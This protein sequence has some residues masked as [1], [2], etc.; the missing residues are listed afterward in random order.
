MLSNNVAKNG[1][2]GAVYMDMQ[3]RMNFTSYIKFEN[4]TA[5]L[6]GAISSYTESYASFLTDA[7]VHFLKNHA[8]NSGGAIY[9]LNSKIIYHGWDYNDTN[10]IRESMSD[11]YLFDS[12]N[13]SFGGA[14]TMSGASKLILNPNVKISLLKIKHNLLV[15]QSLLKF[16]LVPSVQQSLLISDLNVLSC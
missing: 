7:T 4:N 1:S 10:T 14:I 8:K 3:S 9:C 16:S 6:G 15:A 2:G 11:K 13:A 12:N 5:V